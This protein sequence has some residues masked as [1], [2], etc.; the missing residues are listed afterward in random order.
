MK[1]FKISRFI[2]SNDIYFYGYREARVSIVVEF[3][4]DPENYRK[5]LE[6]ICKKVNKKY[7]PDT[8]GFVDVKGVVPDNH[9]C[10]VVNN[11]GI[12]LTDMEILIGNIKEG[13]W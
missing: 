6:Y 8:K 4:T 9:V 10:F 11:I 12:M 7:N 13:R 2:G 1:N 3:R 5:E